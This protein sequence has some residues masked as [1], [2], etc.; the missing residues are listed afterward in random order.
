MDSV[1]S[2]KNLKNLASR[3]PS[4]NGMAPDAYTGI[5]LAVLIVYL[6]Y[7]HYRRYDRLKA[8]ESKFKQVWEDG[9]LTPEQAQEILQNNLFY[10]N[11]LM[12]RL[13]TQ[14]A[15][16]KVYALVCS[17]DTCFYCFVHFSPQSLVLQI[18]S[19]RQDNSSRQ[20]R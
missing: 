11:P 9:S 19:S 15:L 3:R 7:V 17:V 1:T 12:I 2:Q 14:S 16:F 5:S 18:S 8:I 13:G 6:S 10:E 4:L 20:R